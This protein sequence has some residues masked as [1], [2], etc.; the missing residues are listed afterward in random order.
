MW[1]GATF[2]DAAS[3]T[4]LMTTNEYKYLVDNNLLNSETF[5]PKA[6]YPC[7]RYLNVWIVCDD[8]MNPSTSL[9][10]VLAREYLPTVFPEGVYDA[11]ALPL[12]AMM[13]S[14]MRK[15]SAVDMTMWYAN[16]GNLR[17]PAIPNAANTLANK[18]KSLRQAGLSFPKSIVTNYGADVVTHMGAYLGLVPN[19]PRSNNQQWQSQFSGSSVWLDDFCSDTPVYDMWYFGPKEGGM[20]PESDGSSRM[21]YTTQS[22]YYTYNSNN[23]MEYG[24]DQT[25]ITPQQLKRMNWVLENAPGRMMWKDLTAITQ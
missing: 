10:N 15:L 20:E 14:R 21:K 13:E 4:I 22:P 17:L 5:T 8:V 19:S 25:S 6:Y 18:I 16:P 23:I 12:P 11:E 24:S 9:F 1:G 7:T 2:T 3:Q